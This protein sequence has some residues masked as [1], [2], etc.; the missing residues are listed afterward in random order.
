MRQL[1]IYFFCISFL[2]HLTQGTAQD[3]NIEK[4]TTIKDS[5][6][7]TAKKDSL[8]AYSKA[9]RLGTDLYRLIRSQADPDFQGWEFV[10]DFRLKN[11]FYI[12]V[13]VGNENHTLQREQINFTSNGSY[14]KLGFDYNLFE[15]WEG[16]DNQ[17]YIGLRYA[18]SSHAQE[19]N[20]YLVYNRDHYWPDQE[21][22]I[23]NSTG[24]RNDLS[25][26]WIEV[27]AG[28]KVQLIKNFYMG[29]S[30]RLTRLLSDQ[31]PENFDNLYIPGFNRKTDEN[32]FG[33]SLNYTLTYKIPIAKIKKE[34]LD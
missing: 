9:L 21:T 14:L 20:T 23:G 18:Q 31:K 19:V 27:V 17:V 32:S 22:T 10:A 2:A 30:G 24:I 12:A 6:S 11:E 34:N 26:S 1:H 29:F 28:I 3:E 33:A 5:F 7:P 8:I 15:N 16:M 25:A 13:E 4:Q